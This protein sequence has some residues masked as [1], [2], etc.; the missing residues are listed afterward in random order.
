[1]Q[2][3]GDEQHHAAVGR[4]Q[5][6]DCST[7]RL[8]VIRER[9]TVVVHLRG[10]GN[11]WVD[12]FTSQSLNSDAGMCRS[13]TPSSVYDPRS[14]RILRAATASASPGTR[15]TPSDLVPQRARTPSA[16]KGSTISAFCCGYVRSCRRNTASSSSPN[17]DGW[18]PASCSWDQLRK[19]MYI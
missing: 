13:S 15:K 2:E 17:V 11:E 6:L 14:R 10:P 4:R 18:N 3:A 12:P 7:A 5:P 9:D 16:R 1:M 8:C 19:Y